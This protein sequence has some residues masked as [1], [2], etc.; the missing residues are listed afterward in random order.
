MPRKR[1]DILLIEKGLCESPSTAQRLIMAGQVRIG[2]DHVIK[3][4]S[5]TFADDADIRVIE[6][7]P[8][9]SRGAYKLIPAL[10]KTFPEFPTGC[11]ALDLGASTG[12]FTDLLLQRD[13]SKVF[14]A[15]VGY[16]QLHYKL[17]QDE[18]VVNLERTNARYLSREQIP[19]PVD[20]LVADL[21]FIAVQKV[22]DACG[23][24][25]KSGGH[26][27]ILVKP[28]FQAKREE[29]GKGGVIRDPDVRQRCIREVTEHCTEQLQWTFI[30]SI[31]SPV[32]GPKGNQEYI[33]VFRS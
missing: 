14:A 8:Y 29:V 23:A 3:N 22:L 20:I 15:D 16:G 4:A 31:A 25:L 18:R 33:A 19:T 5:Q 21:S 26:A 12:G 9:V 13:A 11:T 10:D 7:C 27:F 1:A 28:Q 32:K 6:P 17:R 24:F 2:D 30:E